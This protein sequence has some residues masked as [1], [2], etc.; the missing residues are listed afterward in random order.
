MWLLRT[1]GMDAG[2]SEEPAEKKQE[3]EFC[4]HERIFWVLSSRLILLKAALG[5][6]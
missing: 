2:V 5:N 6:P 3:D 4:F 1:L